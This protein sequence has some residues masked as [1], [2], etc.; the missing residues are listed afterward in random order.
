MI[1]AK[2]VNQPV[3]ESEVTNNGHKTQDRKMT[4]EKHEATDND[5]DKKWKFHVT[6]MQRKCLIVLFLMNHSY[7]TCH[8]LYLNQ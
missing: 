7:Q 3:L 5:G 1:L 6:A 2:S 4:G 8:M